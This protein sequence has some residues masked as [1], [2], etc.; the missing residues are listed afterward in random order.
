MSKVYSFRLSDENPRE[1]QAR[2]VI[3]ALVSQ[4]YSLRHILTDALIRYGDKGNP[5]SGWDKVYDQLSEIVRELENG[6]VKNQSKH[7]R[8]ALSPGFVEAMKKSAK[9]GKSFHNR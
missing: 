8:S 3:D 2:E 4:G 9:D 5:T 7:N 1:A 6:G